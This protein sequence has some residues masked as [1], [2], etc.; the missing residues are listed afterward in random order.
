MLDRPRAELLEEIEDLKATIGILQDTYAL[1]YLNHKE[2]Y[3]K[4]LKVIVALTENQKEGE[5]V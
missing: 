3:G 5:A 1:E 2:R 4:A